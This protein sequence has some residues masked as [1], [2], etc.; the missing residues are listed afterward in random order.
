MAR[1]INQA[2]L[3][4]IKQ[5]EGLYLTA[6]HGAADRPGLLTIGY[7]HTDAA[8]PPTV[9][10]GM[11]ISKQEAEDI[12]RT[13]LHRC[14]ESVENLVKVAL[15]DN[16]FATLVSF[17]FNV[18]E[19]NFRKSSLLKRLNAGS[20]ASVPQE[21]MKWTK[22]NGKQVQGLANRRAAEAGLWARGD[23]V[24]SNTVEPD[25]APERPSI[26]PEVLGP[27]I[28]GAGGI[29]AP[30]ASG[31]PLLQAALAAVILAGLAVGLFYIIRR[32]RN[33]SR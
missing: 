25:A 17:V 4:L 22:A 10:S 18:G 19:G 20:Y 16:Q 12:L 31:S 8:G 15:T 28:S 7:G 13:D 24:A 5:W 6:Y 11:R 3:D 26:S 2:G 21:L 1:H 32:M 29:V 27:V 23:F 9:K 33:E 14:E 30:L